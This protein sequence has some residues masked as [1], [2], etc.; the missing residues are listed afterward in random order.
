MA[1]K[2]DPPSNKAEMLKDWVSE[3]FLVV[4]SNKES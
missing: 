2:S 4:S 1:Q 3:L